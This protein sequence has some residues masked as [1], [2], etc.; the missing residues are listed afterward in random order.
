MSQI[1]A[2]QLNS[3][4]NIDENLQS[5]E[6]QLAHAQQRGVKLVLLPENCV[7]MGAEQGSSANIAEPLNEGGRVMQRFSALAKQYGVW[8]FVGAFPTLD[9]GTVYQT[10]LVYDDQGILVEHYHKRHL[11]NVTLPDEKES[12]RESDAFSHGQDIK[13]VDTPWGRVG[14]AIC[15][16]LRFPEHFRALI[17]LGATLL[18]LPAAFTHTTGKAH[19]EA[20]LRARAIENQCYV[21]AAGQS[22]HHPGKRQTWGHSM[23][24]N[25]WGVVLDS[26]AEGEGLTVADWDNTELE[27]QRR[28]FPA[29]QH[30]RDN[31]G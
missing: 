29:L 31:V 4:D 23:I 27:H 28:V 22:G 14:L 13:V 18:L 5:I 12:Y 11:F 9:K 20:L 15:Y 19:W 8:L 7:Y 24:I 30:R 2:I 3:Q 21:L 1:A 25:P 26:L 17:D 6:K 16:D 10:L